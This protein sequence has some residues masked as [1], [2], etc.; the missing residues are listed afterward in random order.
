MRTLTASLSLLLAGLAA[1]PAMAGTKVGDVEIGGN[2]SLTSNY[3]FRGISN[4]DRHPAVQG[5]ITVSHTSGLY[6]GLWASSVDFND[7][8]EASIEV[9]LNGGFA[10]EFPNAVKL[11]GG[12]IYYAYPGAN[13]GLEYNFTEV[14]LGV[15]YKY[16]QLGM[17][18][19]YSYTPDY[20]AS[21]TDDS[22]YYVE[23]A[24]T[25][26]LPYGIVASAHY[27][28]S[29]GDAFDVAGRPDSYD[30][31]SIGLSKEVLGFV[32][33]L[34]FTATNDDGRTLYGNN[35]D[36]RFVIKITKNF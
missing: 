28:H 33:D 8:D 32:A 2:M 9:D 34:S 11:D 29:S 13:K 16:Q 14:Y 10:Y 7:G 19:K 3:V 30:D 25:Y 1:T 20:T 5:G 15:S 21:L 6:G 24:L 26:D 35:A 31:Y 12:V 17:S 23:G 27:G 22:A 4:S 36:D 18:A